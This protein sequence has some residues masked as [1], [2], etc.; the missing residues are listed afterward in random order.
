MKKSRSDRIY[1]NPSPA[2]A[3]RKLAR[4]TDQACFTRRI[5]GIKRPV[6]ARC[7]PRYR[8]DVYDRPAFL[9]EH[10]APRGLCKQE[11]AG[12]V[13]VDDVL[14]LF[15]RHVFWHFSPRDA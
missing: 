1:S 3:C 15:E 9:L 7:D 11:T 13:D 4:K 12:E 2:P 5:A 6:R 14:P 8:S 10:D